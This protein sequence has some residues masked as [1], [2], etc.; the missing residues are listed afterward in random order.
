M[1]C[2]RFFDGGG[3]VPAGGARPIAAANICPACAKARQLNFKQTKLQKQRTMTIDSQSRYELVANAHEWAIAKLCAGEPVQGLLVSNHPN[4]KQMTKY[5]FETTEAALAR[6]QAELS[7]ELADATEYAFVYGALFKDGNDIAPV[8]VFRME[9][10]GA[11]AAAQFTQRYVLKKRLFS[12][13]LEFRALEDFKA[14]PA[15]APWLK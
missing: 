4:G 13:R 6:C 8:L 5:E 2:F 15:G 10:R 11:Q 3:G 9:Q 7:G 14:Q 1:S 12:G